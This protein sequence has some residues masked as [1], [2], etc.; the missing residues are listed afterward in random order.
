[1]TPSDKKFLTIL[2]VI[3]LLAAGGL[4]YWGMR[5]GS[6]YQEAADNHEMAADGVRR[7]EGLKPYPKAENVNAKTTALKEYVG[8][9]TNVQAGFVKYRPAELKNVSSA[10]FSARVLEVSE[11]AKE[12][13]TAA[14]TEFPENFALGFEKYTTD[15]ARQE[16]TGLL[17]YQLDGI[18]ELFKMLAESRPSEVANLMREP[19][20]EESAGAYKRGG[21]E[22]ARTLPME[23]TF[24]G[25]E[26]AFRDF[27]NSVVNSEKYYFVIRTLRITNERQTGPTAEEAKFQ[28]IKPAVV[29]PF[30]GADFVFPGAEEEPPAPPA[31]GATPPAEGATPPDAAAPAPAP[32]PAPGEAVVEPAP[33]PAP[34]PAAPVVDDANLILKQLIG[35]EEIHVFMRIDL[36]LFHGDVEL[37]QP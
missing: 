16:A 25:Q 20:P 35:S 2:G 6:R 14:Q 28:E 22:I 5:G 3:T 12:Q 7:L 24:R 9:L 18:G 10:D 1:M 15:P 8:G 30:S 23:V 34:A 29:S 17:G 19:L 27:L 31:D 32:A 4:I 26:R 36:M 33:A 37:P 13:L 21:S 11:A